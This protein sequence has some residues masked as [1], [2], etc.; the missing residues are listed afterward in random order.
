M[1]RAT[2]NSR[3]E[4]IIDILL[5][6]N[7]FARDKIKEPLVVDT[8]RLIV[9]LFQHNP[10]LQCKFFTMAYHNKVTYKCRFYFEN[11]LTYC[12]ITQ[13]L[14]LRLD[15]YKVNPKYYYLV[16]KYLERLLKLAQKHPINKVL[17]DISV[18]KTEEDVERY[19]NLIEVLKE[20]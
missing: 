11:K 8:T 14:W 3:A 13:G 19:F 6:R 15:G 18:L 10:T 4:T 2:I 7:L 17:K 12:W 9:E 5:D 16:P 20:L 1:N